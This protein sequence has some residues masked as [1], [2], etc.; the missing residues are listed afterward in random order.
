M[1][2]LMEMGGRERNEVIFLRFEWLIKRKYVEALKHQTHE[3]DWCRYLCKAYFTLTPGN[4]I[5]TDS[6]GDTGR[7]TKKIV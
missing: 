3:T 7:E 5:L 1:Y 2:L 4:K 6:W